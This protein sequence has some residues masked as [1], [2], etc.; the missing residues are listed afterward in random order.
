MNSMA[1]L[2][3]DLNKRNFRLARLLYAQATRSPGAAVICAWQPS[4]AGDIIVAAAAS[5]TFFCCCFICSLLGPEIV[6]A[7]VF[8]SQQPLQFWVLLQRLVVFTVVVEGPVEKQQRD[9]ISSDA[10]LS[11]SKKCILC[12]NNIFTLRNIITKGRTKFS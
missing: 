8:F 7:P 1:I 10:H 4:I 2:L 12:C 3:R 6:Q 9:E 5:H 11:D